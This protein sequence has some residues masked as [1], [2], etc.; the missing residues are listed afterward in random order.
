[1]MTQA[2]FYK[3]M[4][5]NNAFLINSFLQKPKFNDY[6]FCESVGKKLSITYIINYQN[7]A[8]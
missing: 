3:V 6:R 7:Y 5:Q 8:Q 4:L 2:A 1:M